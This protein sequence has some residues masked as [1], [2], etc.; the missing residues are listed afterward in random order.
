M[1]EP[2]GDGAVDCNVVGNV[3]KMMILIMMEM[4]AAVEVNMSIYVSFVKI[5]SLE[6]DLGRQARILGVALVETIDKGSIL[7]L[8]YSTNR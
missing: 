8:D 5:W 1:S 4:V 2:Q 7:C 6:V 3:D